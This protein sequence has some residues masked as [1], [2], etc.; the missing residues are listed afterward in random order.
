MK[1][2]ILLMIISMPVWLSCVYDSPA[3]CSESEPDGTYLSF[4]SSQIILPSDT[5]GDLESITIESLRI[6]VFSKTTGQIVTNKLFDVGN[7]SLASKD[8]LTG[9][10]II[11]FSHIVVETKPGESIV[12][13]VLN[14]NIM[15]ISN[16]TL[17]GAL[18]M[19]SSLAEM[20]TLV[21]TPLSYTTPLRVIFD[22]NRKPIEPPFIMFTFDEF[23]IAPDRPAENPYTADLRGPNESL[24]GFALDR[25][26]AKVTIDSLSSYPIPGGPATDNEK[27]SYIFILKMGLTNVP[28]QYLWSPN[29]LQSTPP[30][31]NP[32]TVPPS[33]YTGAYQYI[34]FGLEDPTL[35]Y[36]DRDWNGNVQL[37]IDAD[38]HE[39]QELKDSRIWY[40][41]LGSG[42]G[43]YTLNKYALDANLTSNF[44]NVN[45]WVFLSSYPD[46]DGDGD[47]DPYPID[48]NAGNF[49]TMVKALYNNPDSNAYLPTWYELIEPYTIVPEMTGAYWSLKEKNISYYVPEHI[50]SN[51][52]D[53]S[54]ATKLHVKAAKAFIPDTITKEQSTHI[55]WNTTNWGNWEYAVT[56]GGGEF[57]VTGAAFTAMMR[58]IW[59]YELDTIIV[60]SKPTVIVRHYWSGGLRYRSGKVT[61]VLRGS[62][63][64]NITNSTDVMDFYLPV[65]N[66]PSGLVDFNIYRNHEYKFSAHALEQWNPVVANGISGTRSTANNT[67]ENSIM[68]HMNDR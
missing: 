67:G 54:Q 42:A 49:L 44:N 11:D 6:I 50:L 31:P 48:L 30:S 27:T 8:P 45:K 32:Y 36:Y 51:K 24:K 66:T 39:V 7:L 22:T 16:Q 29:R 28:M 60:N 62:Q 47:R 65:R 64:L 55:E 61:G 9:N 4:R 10:W 5:T 19:L 46:S 59:D 40:T 14:E 20:Q 41:G 34:D 1:N 53:P 56:P 13:V 12:Y 17:T 26:M 68:L 52:A 21:K 23:N 25:T 35:G 57:D 58:T 63:F 18:N 37:L 3:D 15:T 33:A 2:I 43:S 38:A